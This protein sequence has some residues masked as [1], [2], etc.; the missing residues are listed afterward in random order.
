V[1]TFICLVWQGNVIT[2]HV[3]RIAVAGNTISLGKG[4]NHH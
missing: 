1:I 4:R 2:E 3:E